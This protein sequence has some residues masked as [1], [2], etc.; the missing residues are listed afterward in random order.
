[1]C[2][3]LVRRRGVSVRGSPIE[4]VSEYNL[5]ETVKVSILTSVSAGSPPVY[6]HMRRGDRANDAFD[7]LSLMVDFVQ[8]GVLVQGDLLVLDNA[9][10]HN[11]NSILYALHTLMTS[12]GNKVWFLPT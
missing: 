10:I 12:A 2:I 9:P 7:F 8:S 4:C 6:V 1:M 3:D 5:S 11:A